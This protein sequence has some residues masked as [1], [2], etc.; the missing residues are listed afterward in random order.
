MWRWPTIRT[1]RVTVQRTGRRLTTHDP[2]SAPGPTSRRSRSSAWRA[3]SSSPMRRR[4]ALGEL[5]AARRPAPSSAGGG[6][7]QGGGRGLPS[8]AFGG[9]D[10]PTDPARSEHPRLPP[11]ADRRAGGGERRA[12]GDQQPQRRSERVRGERHGGAGRPRSALRIARAR[13]APAADPRVRVLARAHVGG[14]GDRGRLVLG[15]RPPG[16]DRADRCRGADRASR[17]AR[18][19]PR[20]LHLRPDRGARALQHLVH[21][22]PGRRGGQGGIARRR[23]APP[24]YHAAARPDHPGTPL[25]RRRRAARVGHLWTHLPPRRIRR[26]RD[27]QVRRAPRRAPGRLLC[28]RHPPARL[29][30]F[31]GHAKRRPHPRRRPAHLPRRSDPGGRRPPSGRRRRPSPPALR[32]GAR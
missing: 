25:P 20:R 22:M 31:R 29:A 4:H 8:A 18:V 19:D 27:G 14:G 3:P 10:R 13:G 11:L 24:P 17:G 15:R 2:G 12:G 23:S 1:G 32:G 7:G 21:P 9:L 30:R 5:L 26:R 6:G 16:P 28:R